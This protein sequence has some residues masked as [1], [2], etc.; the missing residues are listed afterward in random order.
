MQPE[1]APARRRVRTR[2]SGGQSDSDMS[3]DS[4]PVVSPFPED[5]WLTAVHHAIQPES[6]NRFGA[7]RLLTI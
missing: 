7:R 3:V 5:E 1:I 6:P 4:S 2:R